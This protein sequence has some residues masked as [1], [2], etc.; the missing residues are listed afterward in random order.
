M[1]FRL[2][3]KVWLAALA[4]L[5]LAPA[6]AAPQ[7]GPLT[8]AMA[9]LDRG[10]G[11]SAE[12][13]ARAALNAGASHEA[14]AAL[15]GEAELLQG[16]LADARTWLAPGRFSPVTAQRGF[17]ALARLE[18]LDGNFE[19]AARAF[20]RALEH[21]PGTALLWVDIARFRYANGEHRPALAAAE[22]AVALDPAEPR[23]LELRGQ[24]LRD[25]DGLIAAI[26]WFEAALEKAPGDLGLLGEYAATLG[27]A[28]RNTQMLQ[29]ARRMVEI[30][31]RHPRA[32][33]L[34]AV[35]A[36]RA[37]RDDLARRLLSRTDGAYDELPAG[38]LLQGVLELRTGNAALAVEQFDALARLQ[39]DNFTAA[40]LLG[41]ALLANGEANEVVARLGPLA[42]RPAASPYLLALVGRAYEQVDRRADAARYLDRA[43]GPMPA[44]IDVL[45]VGPDGELA[46]W[47]SGA[48]SADVATAVPMLRRMLAEGR[49]D[50]A[51]ALA[52]SL[53]E[54]FS[55]SADIDVLAGDVFLLAGEPG[56]ALAHYRRAAAIRGNFALA[57]RTVFALGALGENAAAERPLAGYLAQDPLSAE[58]SIQLGRVLAAQHRWEAA[59]SLFGH[60][61][62]I[63]GGERDPR[64][65]ADLAEAEL[66]SGDT[67][68]AE[69]TARRAYALQRSNGQ[70]AATLA[71]VLA[72]SGSAGR[73]AAAML[74]KTRSMDPAP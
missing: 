34:Q 16:D 69:A 56:M 13:A 59:A 10:D 19:A 4:V 18:M 37:G 65:L 40:L 57:Q 20:D 8:E 31:P 29:V 61:A 49:E 50:E 30:D 23:A 24:L 6:S 26:A 15:L 70:V 12:V 22:R 60:A 52:A 43:A 2:D 54:R 1:T 63:G 32:Y 66:L 38:R 3:P 58:A 5:A 46:I 44:E 74:A 35:L 72:A 14:V 45:P 17:Q 36:A 42:D 71:R 48:D 73:E 7:G 68:G 27:E 53:S 67:A 47:R 62:H 55:D 51:R 11:V 25:A 64:L 33:Y 9:A 39:P 28:G 41:R 21:G